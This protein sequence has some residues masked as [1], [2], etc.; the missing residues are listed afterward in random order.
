MFVVY[1]FDDNC[2]PEI[3]ENMG[4]MKWFMTTNTDIVEKWFQYQFLRN[5]V[6]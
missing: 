3:I 5:E 6:S 1:N 2:V 4:G